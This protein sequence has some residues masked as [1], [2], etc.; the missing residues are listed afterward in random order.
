M[1]VQARLE[2]VAEVLANFGLHFLRYLT[3]PQ[4][5]RLQRMALAEASTSPD[6]EQAWWDAG[7]ALTHAALACY[8]S[9]PRLRAQLRADAPPALLPTYFISCIAGEYL[10]PA[11]AAAAADGGTLQQQLEARLALF[12]R[13][14]AR[15]A[16]DDR[17]R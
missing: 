16:S 6:M 9:D 8:F 14:A 15:A 5:N 7:P 13:S 17:S 12:L 1:Q 3:D 2:Q 10:C 11:P 4:M